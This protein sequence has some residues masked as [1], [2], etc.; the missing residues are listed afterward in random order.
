MNKGTVAE[1]LLKKVYHEKGK[2][3][4]VLTIGNSLQDEEMIASI[5]KNR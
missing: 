3:D 1:L 2:M 5:K 4:F